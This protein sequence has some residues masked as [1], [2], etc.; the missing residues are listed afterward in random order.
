MQALQAQAWR[1][2]QGRPPPA[3]RRQ[4]R[5]R[6]LA[7]VPPPSPQAGQIP[8]PADIAAWHRYREDAR[9]AG[10]DA[11]EAFARQQ[12]L[13]ARL[14]VLELQAARQAPVYYPDARPQLSPE[15]QRAL[16]ESSA[17]RHDESRRQVGEI[18]AW[19]EGPR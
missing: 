19:L 6:P 10:A 13:E 15:A 7:Q 12:D 17:R 16:D 8:G 5:Y 9:R 1:G 2:P 3:C 18:D 14:T 11:R 4:Q